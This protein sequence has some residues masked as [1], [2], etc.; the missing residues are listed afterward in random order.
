MLFCQNI[1]KENYPSYSD[2]N[3]DHD[4][5]FQFF[6]NQSGYPLLCE[7]WKLLFL[8][9]KMKGAADINHTDQDMQPDNL[10]MYKIAVTS[11]IRVKSNWTN[12]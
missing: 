3:P 2:P 8:H 10:N 11:N 5:I 1:R 4:L 12:K 7:C 6:F 9:G